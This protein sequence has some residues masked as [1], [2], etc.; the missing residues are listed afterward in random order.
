M[1][2]RCVRARTCH[3]VQPGDRLWVELYM[4]F[5]LWLSCAAT[6]FGRA[7]HS[8]MAASSREKDSFLL[9]Y[10]LTVSAAAVAEFGK[11]TSL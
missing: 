3:P 5:D 10:F 11:L 8:H 4:T 1:G 6:L 2:R 9:K 7:Q